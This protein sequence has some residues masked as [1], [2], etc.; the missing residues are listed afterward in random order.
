MNKRISCGDIAVKLDSEFELWKH[1]KSEAKPADNNKKPPRVLGQF[2][3]R[4]INGKRICESM[5]SSLAE[6]YHHEDSSFKGSIL[7]TPPYV[8]DYQ[9]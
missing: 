6:N 3:Y 5:A 9:I 4:T 7:S 1:R 8:P 2:V